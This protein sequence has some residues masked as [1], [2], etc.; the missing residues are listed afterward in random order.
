MERIKEHIK[1]GEYKK[2]YLICGENDYMKNLYADKLKSALVNEGDTM[3]YSEYVGEKVDFVESMEMAYTMPFFS[4]RRLIKF[5]DTG[6]FSSTSDL[7]EQ[8]EGAEESTVFLFVETK[9]DKRN[10]LYKLIKNKGY[11]CEINDLDEKTY[12]AFISK[13]FAGTQ[14]TIDNMC[15]SYLLECVGTDMNTL[16]NECEKLIAYCMD[17]GKV[18]KTDIDTI[19]SILL[20][21]KI[22]EMIDALAVK[23]KAKSL[24]L[25]GDLIKLRESPIKILKLISRHFNILYII[26]CGMGQSLSQDRIITTAKI[27]PFALKKYSAHVKGYSEDELL[28]YVK[29]CTDIEEDFKNGRIDVGIALEMLLCK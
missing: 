15:A 3:N 19:S 17:K 12:I 5:K 22:F 23:D 24:R 9:V 13:C 1:T 6:V 2:Y 20:E 16:T 4:E 14:V 8:L 27:P 10:K 18:E 7:D 28:N 25:Y 29:W 26:K 11:V 21:N